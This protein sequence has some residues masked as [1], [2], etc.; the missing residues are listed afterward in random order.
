M[1]RIT[2]TAEQAELFVSTEDP[3]E[4]CDPAGKILGTIHPPK[5]LEIIAECKR[6]AQSPGP[7]V[8]SAQ[9]QETTRVLQETWDRE[10]PFDQERLQEILREI[11]ERRGA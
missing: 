4:V 8:T 7:W 11:R 1:T 10:G 6:R 5:L 3:I 9:V 2:F